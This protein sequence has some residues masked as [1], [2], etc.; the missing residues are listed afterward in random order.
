MKSMRDLQLWMIMAM[1]TIILG[2]VEECIHLKFMWFI[3]SL[4][5][6]CV[7]VVEFMKWVRGSKR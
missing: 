4:V 2:N 5:L 3:A 1:L 7:V 6:W